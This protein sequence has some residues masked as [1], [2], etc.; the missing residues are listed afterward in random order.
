MVTY[1]PAKRIYAGSNPVGDSVLAVRV[2]D[3][4]VETAYSELVK[5]EI[6]SEEDSP[7]RQ[8]VTFST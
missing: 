6:E 5:G 4:L 7:M 3:A 1:A 2:S 8:R